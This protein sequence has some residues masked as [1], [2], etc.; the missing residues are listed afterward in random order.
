MAST[1]S[2]SLFKSWLANVPSSIAVFLV[3]IPLCLGI[4]HASGAPLLSGLVSGVVGGI[5]IGLLSGAQVSVSGPAAGLAA[6]VFAAISELGGFREFLAA[7]VIAGVLQFFFGVFRAGSIVSVFPSSVIN[8]MMSA[9]GLILIIKQFPH[10][11]GYGVEYLG[12]D[13]LRLGSQVLSESYSS[14]AN[15]LDTS[16][17]RVLRHALSNIHAGAFL[18]GGV[19][20]FSLFAWDRFFGRKLKW[21]PGALIVAIIGVSMKFMLDI[22]GTPAFRLGSAHLV[23]IPVLKSWEDFRHAFVSPQFEVLQTWNGWKVA[24]TLAVV[25]SLETLLSIE[26]MD[27]IDP[28]R[29]RTSPN[30]ELL[31]QGAGNLIA[32]LIGGLPMTSVVVRGSVNVD[33]GAT[34]KSSAIMHGILILLALLL[35]P[36]VLNSIPIAGL[37]AILSYTGFKL[38]NPGLFR[39][40]FKQGWTQ[41][42]P[43]LVTIG[44]VL[45]SDLLIGIFAGLA[46][47]VACAFRSR[48][49]KGHN[50]EG[51]VAF[52]SSFKNGASDR[53]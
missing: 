24:V 41:F 9:I 19:S 20:L 2:V 29:R 47:S 21:I 35:L 40:V 52:F 3:A 27:R 37:A 23:H 15:V 28:L 14:E 34:N 42:L 11:I 13:E 39:K 49:K 17:L 16:I 31:A 51:I 22:S 25:A 33:A 8:G 6:I 30:R 12:T 1:S 38:A 4:A 18:I 10:L 26:A 7:G 53:D 45:L 44:S 36:E 5:V 46:I 32:S 43:F 48:N 50:P